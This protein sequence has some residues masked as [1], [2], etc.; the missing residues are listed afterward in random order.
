[1]T[2]QIPPLSYMVKYCHY[3]SSCSNVIIDDGVSKSRKVVISNGRVWK[4]V[5]GRRDCQ[6][7]YLCAYK[8]VSQ[9]TSSKYT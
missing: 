4:Q 2:L 5:N 6:T 7:L 3:V 9:A 8:S 1:M